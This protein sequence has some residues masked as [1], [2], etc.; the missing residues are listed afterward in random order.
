MPL[1]IALVALILFSIRLAVSAPFAYGDLVTLKQG[2]EIR[3][4]LLIE[5][6]GK[7]SKAKASAELVT[8]RTLSGATVMV[9]RS[10]VGAVIRRR[11]IVEEYETRRRALS[12]TVEAHWELAE[13]CRQKSLTKER[14][15]EL[16][17][18]LVLDKE[19]VAAHRA[20]GHIQFKGNWATQ[21]EMMR[22]RGLVKHKGKYVLAQE[23]ELLQQEERVSE[24]E[25]AWFKKV[26]LWQSWLEGGQVDR[27]N[28]AITE[29]TAIKEPDAVAA[30]SKNFRNAEIEDDRMM[31]VGILDKIGGD[32]PLQPL[33]MQSLWDESNFVRE[34]AVKGVRHRNVDKALPAYVRALKNEMNMLVNRAG[35]AL[36]ELGND[37]VVP[38]LI[39]ALVTRHSY[40]ILVPDPGVGNFRTDGDMADPTQRVLPP[41]I[42][43]RL[44]TGQLPFGVEVITPTAPR[45][46]EVPV[47]RDEENPDVLNALTLL[48]GENFGF[49]EPTWRN[50]YNA[51]HNLKQF[52]KTG[53]KIKAKP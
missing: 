21:D 49:D 51:K 39:D 5:S 33:V 23:L 42:A 35:A 30:L 26:R 12:D 15:A 27:K 52:P 41:S 32:K 9:L 14:E 40:T 48:T 53:R 43:G 17:K 22:A 46:K 3:G 45:M 37:S 16:Q 6:E 29:L 31:Y 44:A 38:P 47:E 20:L 19:H 11:P 10:E 1:R 4:E 28:K 24:A 36:G 2:G 25:K 18:V 7:A 50:W 8:I 34:A 13:W